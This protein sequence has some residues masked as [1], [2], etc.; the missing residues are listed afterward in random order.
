MK[1]WPFNRDQY[2]KNPKLWIQHYMDVF[3]FERQQRLKN[4]IYRAKLALYQLKKKIKNGFR[5]TN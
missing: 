4:P 5:R 2:V 1:P 3:E